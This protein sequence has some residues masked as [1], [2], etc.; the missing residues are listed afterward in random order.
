MIL[1]KIMIHRVRNLFESH[2]ELSQG[3]NLI[4]GANGS[5]KSSILESIHLLGYGRSFRS[6]LTRPLIQFGE[7]SLVIS[8]EILSDPLDRE[9]SYRFGYQK[10]ANAAAIIRLNQETVTFI[11]MVRLFPVQIIH[12]ESFEQIYAGASPRR[13]ILDWG[14]FHVEPTFGALWS[15]YQ[16]ALKQRNAALKHAVINMEITCWDDALVELGAQLEAL[17]R[18]W[19]PDFLIFLQEAI[20]HLLPEISPALNLSYYPGWQSEEGA[21]LALTL[22]QALNLSFN[23]DKFL[24]STQIGPHRADLIMTY[25]KLPL[26]KILSRGQQKL[27]MMA[28]FMAQAKWLNATLGK[29]SLLLIDDVISELDNANLEKLL[30]FIANQ[31]QQVIIT[32]VDEKGLDFSD[33]I[34]DLRRFCIEKGKIERVC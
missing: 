15:N 33:K 20:Y 1:T 14:M 22:G 17:R 6:H 8:A 19:V 28:F 25:D 31:Q 21:D 23:R 29:K 32:A 4:L 2:I 3:V 10:S 12:P 18:R 11:E 26:E 9:T 34:Q 30:F 13:K 24:G 27:I 16:K 7:S 5:G